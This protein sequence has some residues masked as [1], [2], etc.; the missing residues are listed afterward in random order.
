MNNRLRLARLI[1]AVATATVVGLA[2]CGPTYAGVR[3][4]TCGTP[5]TPPCVAR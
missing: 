4:P 3:P 2:P 1:V 5:N